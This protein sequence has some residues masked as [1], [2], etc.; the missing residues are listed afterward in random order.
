M[1]KVVGRFKSDRD[2]AYTEFL[3]KCA[4]FDAEIAK[5]R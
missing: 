5:E 3:D 2:D 4:D 1:E